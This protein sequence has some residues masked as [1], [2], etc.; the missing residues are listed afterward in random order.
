[1]YISTTTT[2][3]ILQ[4]LYRTT[5]ISQHLQ[6][7]TGRFCWSKV[8]MPMCCC[9]RQVANLD[10]QCYLRTVRHPSPYWK[11]KWPGLY[12]LWLNL[13][14]SKLPK[15]PSVL[16]HCCLGG[17]KGIRPVKNWVMRYWR[18]YLSGARCKWFAYAQLMPLPPII[19]C[20]SKIQN[21]LASGAGLPGLSWKKG[22]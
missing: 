15:L 1:M 16:W 20:S 9:W 11:N 13:K 10:Q 5:C 7:R 12:L 19:S 22:R 6:L 8:L 17:R 3:T 18:G 14:H 21:G 2:T 4:P